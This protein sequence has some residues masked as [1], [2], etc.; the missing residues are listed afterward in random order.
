MRQIFAPLLLLSFAST[1]SPAQVPATRGPDGGTRTLISS[2]AVLPLP[3]APF[4]ATSKIT[5]T[6]A[7][8]EGGSVVTYGIAKIY[9]DSEGRVYRERHHFSPDPNVDPR[10]TLVEFFVRDPVA[11]T[12]T[13]CIRATRRCTIQR[14][15]N[16]TAVPSLQPVGPFDGGKRYLTR[17][18]LGNQTIENLAAVGTMETVTIAVG[19]I[20]NDRPLK[21]TR[22]FWYSPDLQTNVKVIRIDPREGTEDVS[23]TDVSRTEPDPKVFAIPPGYSAGA[24][25]SSSDIE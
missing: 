4:S 21:L 9:R 23:I 13:L 17:E 19:A 3:G 6:R 15:R 14:L 22:E 24:A 2:V 11:H 7:A 25:P 10:T 20:G 12:L 1:L 18:S 5:F 8:G 16:E